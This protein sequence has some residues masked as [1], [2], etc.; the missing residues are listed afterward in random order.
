M[1]KIAR[2]TGL[3]SE[4]L[5]VLAIANGIEKL[6]ERFLPSDPPKLQLQKPSPRQQEVLT[7][8]QCGQSVKEIADQLAVKEATVRTHIARLRSRLSA[9]DLLNLRYIDTPIKEATESLQK[10]D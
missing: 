9:Q 5:I 6:E 1:E 7:L 8:L 10:L 4:K 3:N 2:S